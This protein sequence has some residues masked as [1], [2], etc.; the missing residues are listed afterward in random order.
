MYYYL[1]VL[2]VEQIIF[3]IVFAICIF[4]LTAVITADPGL[5]RKYHHART[6]NWTYCDHCESFRPPG[7]VHC[8]TCQVCIAVYDHHCPV[9][10]SFYKRVILFLKII[11]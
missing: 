7:T 6:R 5:D 1:A 4:G 10:K 3:D 11:S 2:L 8:S 9:S